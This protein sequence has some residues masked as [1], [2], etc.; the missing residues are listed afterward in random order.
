MDNVFYIK[1]KN[2]KKVNIPILFLVADEALK[3]SITGT[4]FRKWFTHFFENCKEAYGQYCSSGSVKK[5]KTLGRINVMTESFYSFF[6]LQDNEPDE[7]AKDSAETENATGTELICQETDTDNSVDAESEYAAE[8]EEDVGGS[9]DF[10]ET[11]STEQEVTEESFSSDSKEPAEEMENPNESDR[12]EPAE[13]MGDSTEPDE[14]S[15]ENV[16]DSTA[17]ETDAT[18]DNAEQ[19]PDGYEQETDESFSDDLQKGAN[20]SND[21]GFEDAPDAEDADSEVSSDREDTVANNSF[22]GTMAAKF[23]SLVV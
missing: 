3:Q 19:N 21:S 2:L 17:Q 23:H 22:F 7:Q 1:N 8:Q 14:E 10:E 6:Q 13:E 5:E 4:N 16:D 18:K 15:T 9:G 12:E 20:E 11:A